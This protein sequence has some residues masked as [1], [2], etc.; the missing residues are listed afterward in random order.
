M[1]TIRQNS[2]EDPRLIVFDIIVSS[3]G[4]TKNDGGFPFYFLFR[5][6]LLFGFPATYRENDKQTDILRLIAK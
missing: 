4:E 2:D 1:V 5:I 3:V 6:L